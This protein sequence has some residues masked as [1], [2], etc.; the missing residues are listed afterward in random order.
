LEANDN[1]TGIGLIE[2]QG[3]SSCT[4]FFIKP[5]EMSQAPAYVLTN[6]HCIDL[7]SNLPTASEVIVDRPIKTLFRRDDSPLTFIP[8]YFARSK[9]P[10]RSYPV[11]KVVYATMKDTDVALLELPMTQ[12]ELMNT[13]IVPLTIS[14]LPGLAGEKIEVVGVPGNKVPANRQFLHRSTC[15]LGRTVRVQEGVYQW[16][17]ALKHRCS[18]VSG[19]SGSPMLAQGKVIGIINTGGTEPRRDDDACTL[20]HPCE[21][22]DNKTSRSSLANYGQLLDRLPG[23]FDQQGTFSLMNPTCRL[24]KPSGYRS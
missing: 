20:D 13:G 2:I 7:L 3:L 19:M 6:A 4:G 14:P 5:S 22:P 17:N 9:K 21:Q 16:N 8:N 11:K 23:C 1:Y 24:A 10:K 15:V 12:G 18:I